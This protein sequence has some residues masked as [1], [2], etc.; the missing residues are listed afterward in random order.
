MLSR[1]SH[2]LNR[3]SEIVCC[4]VLLAMTVTV[5][6]QVVCRYLLGAALTW[7]EEFARYGLVWITFLGA[8]IAL[9]RRA[10]MGVLAI[11]EMFSPGIR[12]GVQV[13][14]VFAV[15]VFLFIATLKGTEL[16]VFNMKQFSPAMGLPMGYVYL[17]IPMGCLVMIIHAA[18][19]LLDLLRPLPVR[20]IGEAGD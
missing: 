6:L 18:D 11:V 3:L 15:M 4:G 7:S 20:V 17:A 12:K 2:W 5:V 16:A 9:K 13:F 19:H 14:T 1:V 10:H 8:G